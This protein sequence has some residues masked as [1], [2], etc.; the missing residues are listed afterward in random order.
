MCQEN[1]IYVHFNI[2]V[3]RCEASNIIRVIKSRWLSR[4]NVYY[5]WEDET[6]IQDMYLESLR[7]HLREVMDDRKIILKWILKKQYVTV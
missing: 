4:R 2:Y 1:Y 6:C 5:A 7:D 3:F